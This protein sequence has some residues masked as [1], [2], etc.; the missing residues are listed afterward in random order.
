MNLSLASTLLVPRVL[1]SAPMDQCRARIC[2][3]EPYFALHNLEQTANFLRASIHPQHLSQRESG[4]ITGAEAGRHLAILGSCAAA[5]TNPLAER[6]FYLAR[7]ADLRLLDTNLRLAYVGELVA[8]A[9]GQMHGRR[10][11]SCE[12]EIQTLAGEGIYSLH[13]EYDVLRQPAFERINRDF[14]CSA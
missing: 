5:L 7:R 8:R 14:R 4:P 13:V 2:V 1:T 3:S 9:S 12:A 6:H 11:A 10:S